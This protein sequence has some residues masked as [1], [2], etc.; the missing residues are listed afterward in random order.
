[1]KKSYSTDDRNHVNAWTCQTRFTKGRIRSPRDSRTRTRTRAMTDGQSFETESPWNSD[2]INY[3][4]RIARHWFM[5]DQLWTFKKYYSRYVDNRKL[6]RK[7]N[8]GREWKGNS[9]PGSVFKNVSHLQIKVLLHIEYLVTA[10]ES[11]SGL[12]IDSETKRFETEIKSDC[13]L[14]CLRG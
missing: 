1:M 14:G 9:L 2:Y 6:F 11:R 13:F 7:S 8:D 12:M 4:A 5:N 10:S 3:C